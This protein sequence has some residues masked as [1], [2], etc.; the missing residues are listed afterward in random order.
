M[1][2]RGSAR[3]TVRRPVPTAPPSSGQQPAPGSSPIPAAR[4]RRAV[5]PR[6]PPRRG[7]SGISSIRSGRTCR[8]AGRLAIHICITSARVKV[9]ATVLLL[10]IAAAHR[11]VECRRRAAHEPDAPAPTP[12][13]LRWRRPP[14][15]PASDPRSGNREV[16]PLTGLPS[17]AAP[18][19]FAMGCGPSPPPV[20]RARSR[21]RREAR[22]GARRASSR[23]S[24]PAR[25]A[26][27]S[28]T[29]PR[30]RQPS[31]ST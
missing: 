16:G 13:Q 11:V 15:A 5:A 25:A 19:S 23:S 2:R 29:R 21:N 9:D 28:G 10:R 7:R 30:S 26:A 1:R 17:A 27:N 24:R 18:R 4:A 8:R 12:G 6:L 20:C 3:R 22:L 14:S 31:G